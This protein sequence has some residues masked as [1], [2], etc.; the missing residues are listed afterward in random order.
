MEHT[1]RKLTPAGLFEASWEDVAAAVC[2]LEFPC[3]SHFAYPEAGSTTGSAD[4]RRARWILTFNVRPG[5][6]AHRDGAILSDGMH[7]RTKRRRRDRDVGSRVAWKRSHESVV[8]CA[9][10]TP[11]L[12][13]QARS[14]TLRRIAAI[15]ANLTITNKYL[16]R[17]GFGS[18]PAR[19]ICKSG[20]RGSFRRRC[21]GLQGQ[22]MGM[23]DR[24]EL[25]WR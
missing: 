23:S 25:K 7:R 13:G 17:A 18:V 11:R 24:A 9:L 8:L 14:C 15:C 20:L 4:G 12:D 6:D 19:R 16:L 2:A 5:V 22:A 10:S 1:D 3:A 21:V